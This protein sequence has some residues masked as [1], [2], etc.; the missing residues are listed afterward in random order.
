MPYTWNAYPLY[1]RCQFLPRHHGKWELLETS[2]SVLNP[3]FAFTESTSF[4]VSIP[5][6]A[7]TFL[8][9]TT[10]TTTS[11]CSDNDNL[12]RTEATGS[13]S[14]TLSSV[15][16]KLTRTPRVSEIL[17][18]PLR[19]TPTAAVDHLLKEV[20]RYPSGTLFDVWRG[21]WWCTHAKLAPL[22]PHPLAQ[23]RHNGPVSR[24]RGD[25]ARL[26][27]TVLA[28]QVCIPS[29]QREL[30]LRIYIKFI[31]IFSISEYFSKFLKFFQIFS[32]PSPELLKRF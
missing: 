29:A 10:S 13:F 14:P 11:L 3:A 6:P 23:D 27:V 26:L 8:E 4:T 12:F 31:L 30:R 32:K 18:G 25:Q 24:Q 28:Q 15:F 7:P 5:N 9:S 16:L 19:Q 1:A 2:L 20:G 17:N 22:T 21:V